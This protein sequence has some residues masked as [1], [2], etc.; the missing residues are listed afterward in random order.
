MSAIDSVILFYRALNVPALTGQINGK[1]WR[2]NR[3][4][5]SGKTDVV[6][7]SP[8]YV[9]GAF[10]R[11]NIE[12]NVFTPNKTQVI[13]GNNDT[14]HPDIPTLDRLT[15]IIVGLLSG[16]NFSVVGKVLRDK[17]GHW[18][19]NNVIQLESIDPVLGMPAELYELTGVSDGYGGY[20]TGREQ[21]W[22]G[23]VSMVDIKK[24]SQLNVDN[25]SN[26]F[27]QIND[28]IIPVTPQKNYK[29]ITNEAEYTIL[30]IT[31]ESVGLWRIHTVRGDFKRN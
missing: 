13:D 16:Y 5:N 12:I 30:G 15:D 22:S 3:P 26:A 19:S 11:V 23:R 17:D 2:Y 28:F 9:G 4:L 27:N 20:T 8:E 21:V 18:Y 24:G 31:P 25:S 6:I 1:V 14:T 10:N 29:L 7:S